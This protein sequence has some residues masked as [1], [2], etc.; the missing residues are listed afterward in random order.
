ML[1]IKPKEEPK[2]KRVM[3]LWDEKLHKAAKKFADNKGISVSEL[4]R[5]AVSKVLESEA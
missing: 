5:L 4:S 1:Q 3:M 2:V